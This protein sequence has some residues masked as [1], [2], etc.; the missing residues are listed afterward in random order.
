MSVTSLYHPLMTCSSEALICS[1]N[2]QHNCAAQKCM[3]SGT[4]PV[5][6]EHEKTGKTLP[7]IVHVS[8]S[9][10]I[11]N[12]AQM[13]DA[14]HV[15]RFR[16]QVEPFDRDWAIHS[17]ATAELNAQK[18]KTSKAP[19]TNAPSRSASGTSSM[20]ASRFINMFSSTGK[21]TY[22][23]QVLSMLTNAWYSQQAVEGHCWHVTALYQ[24]IDH[25]YVGFC[26]SL[27]SEIPSS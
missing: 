4:Q 13:R 11:L 14:S 6:E 24:Q 20:V 25:Q 27:V 23:Y 1:V 26:Q 3:D 8:P 22:F 21:C 7:R 19:K 16:I 10:L 12:T 9:D 2:V 18:M 5:Y 17:G 15:Q